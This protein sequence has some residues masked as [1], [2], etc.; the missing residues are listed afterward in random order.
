MSDP[1]NPQT[2]HEERVAGSEEFAS[3]RALWRAEMG[4]DGVLRQQA[5]NLQVSA[6]A[7]HHTYLWE[8][9]G[10]PVIRLPDDIVVLQELIW[11]YRPERIVETGIARGGS[12]ILNASL[13]ILAGLEPHVL[14]V[15]ISIFPHT[16]SDLE[17]HP[18]FR[19]IELLEA[20][21]TSAVARERAGAFLEGSQ[22]AMLVLDSN[23]T[24]DHVLS[25]LE[26]LAPLLPVGSFV[27]VAD[28]LIEEFP[29]GHYQNRPWDRGNNPMTAAR[30]F[31]AE[32][33]DFELD[34][35][36]SRRALLTEFRDGI[37]RRVS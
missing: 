5:V 31:V 27:L 19:G 32:H 14:G 3:D 20:D 17:Q 35:D 16:R 24:H 9:L 13:Q 33:S 25:E 21:S 30:R 37:L 22:R 4:A 15:D 36:W 1:S 8:W 10:V 18:L 7:H 2:L 28:T 12:M 11:D 26:V 23:H 34:G 29:E 6:D